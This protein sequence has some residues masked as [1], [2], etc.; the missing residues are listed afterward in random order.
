MSADF[1]RLLAASSGA[2]LSKPAAVPAASVAQRDSVPRFSAIGLDDDVAGLHAIAL[3]KWHDQ[4]IEHAVDGIAF[5]VPPPNV[6]AIRQ[7]LA[8]PFRF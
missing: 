3:L 6:A 7:R 2:P 1:L 4:Q 8:E 5:S